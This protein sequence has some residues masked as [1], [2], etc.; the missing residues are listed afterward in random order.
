MRGRCEFCLGAQRGGMTMSYQP[1]Y[2]KEDN[3]QDQE[4]SQVCSIFFPNVTRSPNVCVAG[5]HLQSTLSIAP[6]RF[7]LM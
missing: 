6:R 7:F 2:S 4:E 3:H 5:F 1:R